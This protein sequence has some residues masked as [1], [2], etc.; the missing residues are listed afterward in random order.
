MNFKPFKNNQQ[1]EAKCHADT[2]N[3]NW[4]CTAAVFF[5]ERIQL[6]LKIKPQ[7]F[8]FSPHLIPQN[9]CWATMSF[10]I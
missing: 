2:K 7:S 9:G 3:C 6:F 8:T 4:A 5:T 10:K 1:F